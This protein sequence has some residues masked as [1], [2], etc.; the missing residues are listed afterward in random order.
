MENNKPYYE[1]AVFNSLKCASFAEILFP[2]KECE[3]RVQGQQCY[4]MKSLNLITVIITYWCFST[5]PLKLLPRQ[6]I[7]NFQN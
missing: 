4:Q 3:F 7:V 2:H 5:N 1:M 6:Q